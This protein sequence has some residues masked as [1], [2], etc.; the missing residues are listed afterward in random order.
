MR[1]WLEVEAYGNPW[2]TDFSQIQKLVEDIAA[3]C[4]EIARL[5]DENERLRVV[6]R[7]AAELDRAAMMHG[8]ESYE[9]GML[10]PALREGL[11]TTDKGREG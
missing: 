8:Q 11:G 3:P 5:R 1:W 10:L 9:V 4:E 2:T 7:T 6:E